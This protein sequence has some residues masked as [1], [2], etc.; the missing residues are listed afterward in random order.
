VVVIN[1]YD[2]LPPSAEI[3]SFYEDG[4]A[5]TTT[6]AFLTPRS[7]I[8]RL[9]R[10]TRPSPRPTRRTSGG[11][12]SSA[13]SAWPPMVSGTTSRR[14][15]T[16]TKDGRSS[17]RRGTS[18]ARGTRCPGSAGPIGLWATSPRPSATARKASRNSR[19]STTAGESRPAGAGSDLPTSG[20]ATSPPQH[21]PSE[22]G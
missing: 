2:Y 10:P 17:S 20:L 9:H 13:S 12:I 21:A 7:S 6:G 18:E 15:S 3:K 19:R 4:S 8:E 11:R 22:P 5:R 14:P 16:T 1:N